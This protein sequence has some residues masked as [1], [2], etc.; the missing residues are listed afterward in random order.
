MLLLALVLALSLVLAVPVPVVVPVVVPVPAG[1]A[2]RTG[3]AMMVA[4]DHGD[5]D[6]DTVRERG[7][8][9]TTRGHGTP[10]R[11]SADHEYSGQLAGLEQLGSPWKGLVSRRNNPR[12]GRWWKILNL[13][14]RSRFYPNAAWP[15]HF[16][17]NRNG[18]RQ[19]LPILFSFVGGRELLRGPVPP[20]FVDRSKYHSYR[21]YFRPR[22]TPPWQAVVH[23]VT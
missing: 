19:I 5:G 11:H 9:H 16:S 21:S 18:D 22:R 12:I 15:L 23:A 2:G 17:G 3:G 1:A 14:N 7:R 13:D 10:D 6:G 20:N 4:G 8:D